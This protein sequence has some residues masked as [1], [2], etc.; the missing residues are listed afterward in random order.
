M[1]VFKISKFFLCSR[2]APLNPHF[3]TFKKE[4]NRY[5]KKADTLKTNE[6]SPQT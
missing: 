5:K 4:K 3:G 6:K 1:S 2:H